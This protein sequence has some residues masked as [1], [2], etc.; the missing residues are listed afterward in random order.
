MQAGGTGG[1][2]RQQAGVKRVPAQLPQHGLPRH[3]A[4]A[5][6][7]PCTSLQ[8]L[9]A[10]WACRP[11]GATVAAGRA[12]GS[13]HLPAGPAPRA[14]RARRSRAGCAAASAARPRDSSARAAHPR[15]CPNRSPHFRCQSP[16]T[17]RGVC[18]GLTWGGVA[19]GGDRPDWTRSGSETRRRTGQQDGGGREGNEACNELQPSSACRHPIS[20]P[21]QPNLAAQALRQAPNLAAPV[22]LAAAA[23][24]A[25]SLQLGRLGGIVP[26]QPTV[27]VVTPIPAAIAAAAAGRPGRCEKPWPGWARPERAGGWSNTY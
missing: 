14:T 12:G 26:G 8:A 20:A 4:A 27:L 5:Q 24:A 2:W 3:Q 18:R 10:L 7:A 22:S 25:A 1:Q 6:A 16:E 15:R 11:A 17:G 13:T 21:R 23:A 19:V 9:G